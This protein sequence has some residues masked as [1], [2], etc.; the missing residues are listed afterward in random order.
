MANT[1]DVFNA[2]RGPDYWE[3]LIE[4]MDPER[5]EGFGTV[6]TLAE[7]GE[8]S[9]EGLVLADMREFDFVYPRYNIGSCTNFFVLDGFAHAGVRDKS[10]R[11]RKG[12]ELM[13][14]EG[15][16]HFM[17]THKLVVAIATV[18]QL[19]GNQII[20]VDDR[21]PHVPFNKALFRQIAYGQPN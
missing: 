10:H 19:C 11:L 21:H 16:V 2:W 6:Y 4:G 12:N 13:V 9:T 1:R 14:R 18:P 17:A 7:P 5:V 8:T 3:K 20:S 15:E